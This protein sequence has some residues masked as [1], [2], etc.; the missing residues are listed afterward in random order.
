MH[1][2]IKRKKIFIT[3]AVI[4]AASQILGLAVLVYLNYTSVKKA[5]LGVTFSSWQARYLGLDAGAVLA[6]SLEDL[7]IKKYRIPVYW[8][9]T[10]AKKGKYDFS[11]VD[12]QL[13]KIG[14]EGG[15]V[16]LAIGRRLPRWPECHI[17][18]WAKSLEEKQQQ[19]LV[20]KMLKATVN[21]FKNRAII[22]AWQV[23]NEPML[24]GYGECPPPDTAFLKQEVDLVRLLDS[25]PIVLTE[26]GELSTWAKAAELADEIG[27]SIYRTVWSKTLGLFTYPLT[28]AYYKYRAKTLSLF[29]KKVF[30][31]E[32]QIEPWGN[33]AL[34]YMP[35]VDQ[36][37]I[38]NEKKAR[39]S[40]KF[41]KQAGFDEAYLWGVEWWAYLKANGDNGMWQTIKDEV[42]KNQ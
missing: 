24:S 36:K 40:I 18:T 7:K 10:E 29:V 21:H 41:A 33:V 4:I 30:V 42:A 2:L 5:T 28:P 3:I 9:F 39:Q 16:L 6:G 26:S 17:P 22:E 38:M 20:L 13:D 12:W 35:I 14:K 32:L 34:I 31:S 8:S 19:E 15:T 27:I 23:E 1:R 11:D 25:R 37:Y